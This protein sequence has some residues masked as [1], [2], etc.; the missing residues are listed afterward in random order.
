MFGISQFLAQVRVLVWSGFACT[1]KF[2]GRPKHHNKTAHPKV[3]KYPRSHCLTCKTWSVKAAALFWCWLVQQL[4]FDADFYFGALCQEPWLMTLDLEGLRLRCSVYFGSIQLNDRISTHTPILTSADRDTYG[5]MVYRFTFPGERYLYPNFDLSQYDVEREL[6]ASPYAMFGLEYVKPTTSKS[7]GEG[8]CGLCVVVV[9]GRG[10]VAC[11]MV[12]VVVV[13]RGLLCALWCMCVWWWWGGGLLRALWCVWWW[14][15]GGLL[16]ALWCVCVWWWEGGL[17]HALW[18]VWWWWGWGLLHALWCVC[19]GG[20]E[21]GCCMHYGVCVWWWLGGGLLHALWC[22]CVVVVGRGLLHALWCVVVVGRGLLCALWCMCVWWW[23]GG[24]LL[25]ALWCMWW[26]WGGGC[27]MHYGVCGGGGRG[28]V[29][30]IMVHVCVVVVGRGVVACIMV[31][32][33]GGGGYVVVCMGIYA[34]RLSAT[35][36]LSD[37]LKPSPSQVWTSCPWAGPACLCSAAERRATR[38]WKPSCCWK[39]RHG[40]PCIPGTYPTASSPPSLP[41]PLRHQKVRCHHD[42]GERRETA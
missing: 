34:C 5:N 32:V 27:C 16:R 39:G 23:W 37:A 21:G 8:W 35:E 29:A 9:V 36:I 22:V 40:W 30:G 26:W 2:W 38:L 24:G 3:D 18:C 13:G 15:G 10:V 19:G 42:Q 20:G 7:S 14:W 12:H 41:R 28:V 17:L 31:C 1:C 25:R 4:N 11:I 33:V 6:G